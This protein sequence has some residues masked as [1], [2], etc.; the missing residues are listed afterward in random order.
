MMDIDSGPACRVPHSKTLH[1]LPSVLD[2][3]E[4]GIVT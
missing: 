1:K 2:N 3:L 4:L